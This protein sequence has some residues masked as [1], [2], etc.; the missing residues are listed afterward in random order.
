MRSLAVDFCHRNVKNNDCHSF[1]RTVP[2]SMKYFREL[3][4]SNKAN[5]V[6]KRSVA[7]MNC[8]PEDAAVQIPRNMKQLRNLRYKHLNQTR[9][10]QD[11][12]Y[13]IHELAYDSP[14]FVWKITTFPDLV[15]ICGLQ[16]SNY[17]IL[18]FVNFI[19]HTI[20]SR[21]RLIEPPRDQVDLT[22]LSG[23]SI[24]R[25]YCKPNSNSVL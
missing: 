15:L 6:Y 7:S 4:K 22:R 18:Y 12:L 1:I 23:E 14:G 10:S 16:V 20:Y 24:N 13:N 5:V 9:I 25:K 8:N 21:L 3:Y 11:M 17:Q 19:T 2:S